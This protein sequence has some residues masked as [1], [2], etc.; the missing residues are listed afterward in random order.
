MG[1]QEAFTGAKTGQVDSVDVLLHSELSDDAKPHVRVQ[2]AVSDVDVAFDKK[3]PTATKV[4]GF[5][6]YDEFGVSVDVKSASLLD[7]PV[8]DLLLTVPILSGSAD[9]LNLKGS[10]NAPS[11]TILATLRAT[12]LADTVLQPFNDWQLEGSVKGRFEIGIPFSEEA[13]PKV[14]LGLVF[15]DNPLLIKEI[16]LLSEIQNGHLNYSS[17]EG[18]T[19]SSFDIKALGG[20]SHLELS[21][22]TSSSGELAVIGDFSGVVDISEVA[23]W[24]KLPDAAIKKV[25]GK[26]AYTA[27]LLVNQAQDGQIDLTVD[28]DLMGISVDLPEPVGKTAQET[29]SLRIKVMQ[30]ERD[31][32]VD[33]DY[34]SLSK[35]RLL[36]QDSEFVGGE[37]ILSGAQD[38]VLSSTI[39]KG[40][41]LTGDFKRFYVQDWQS[42]FTDFSGGASKPSGG[43]S[44]PSADASQSADGIKIPEFP[45]WLS[46][47][48]MKWS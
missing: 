47:L 45:K 7:L 17:S 25:S 48:L 8:K 21:S 39:P 2:M 10:V 4:N 14:Q 18:I 29:R 41:V 30:H 3:W 15:Q 24:R 34:E 40:L 32:V 5:F 26:S 33:M 9:W 31:L 13:Q 20:D 22:N 38:Q 43:A 36:L 12:P 42:V 11:S 6:E 1:I 46:R 23:A 35:A 19:N 27:K 37:L 16:D 28:S 44:K